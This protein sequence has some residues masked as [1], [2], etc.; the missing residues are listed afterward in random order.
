MSEYLFPLFAYL[1]GSISSAVVVARLMHLQDPRTVGSGNPGATNVLR[2]GGKRAAVVTLIGDTLKGVMAVVLARFLTQ[3]PV[4]LA[5]VMGSVFLG[6]LYPVF[7]GFKGGKGVAT[8]L[9]AYLGFDPVIGGLLALTWLV[10][11][12]VTRYSSLSALVAAALSPIFVWWRHPVPAVVAIS[13]AVAALL[14]WRHRQ[15]IRRLIAGT[16]TRIG[17]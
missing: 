15:N 13:V 12:V 10:V 5:A 17:K 14:Y 2:Y 16:E 3:D 9:G 1:V 4:V 8:A 6:H 7:F 11:A